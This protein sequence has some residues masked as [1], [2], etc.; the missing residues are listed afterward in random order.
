MSNKICVRCGIRGHTC[1]VC[2]GPVT[3]F[4]LIV[5]S[6]REIIENHTTLGNIYSNTYKY[7][8]DNKH[9]EAVETYCLYKQK[10]KDIKDDLVFLLVERKDSIA[11]ISLIQGVYSEDKVQVEQYVRDLTCEE[12]YTLENLKWDELWGIAGSNKKNKNMLEKKFNNLNIKE[13]LSNC[14]CRFRQ[15]DYLMP[16]GRLKFKEDVINGAL[17]EF[18]EETGYEKRDV[19]ICNYPNSVESFTGCNG[20]TYKNVYFVAKLNAFARIKTPLY[21]LPEQSK[22]VRNV[23]W[24]S[25][26]ECMNKIKS[27]DKKK[28]LYNTWLLLKNT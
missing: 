3:S 28:L 25:I 24:F 8:C 10:T 2:D 6:T 13:Y 7:T 17:R 11:F 23:G 1:K 4:G 18:S 20:N 12:R 22:E 5:Y 15:A 21:E 14:P 19:T 16:K 9:E 26:N 27:R